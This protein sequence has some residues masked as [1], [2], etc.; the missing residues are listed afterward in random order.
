MLGANDGGR[1]ASVQL[2]KV[3]KRLQDDEVTLRKRKEAFRDD[4]RGAE[5]RWRAERSGMLHW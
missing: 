2:V 5:V 1:E 4:L 3:V